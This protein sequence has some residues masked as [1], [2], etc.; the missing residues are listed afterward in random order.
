MSNEKEREGKTDEDAFD[1]L[2]NSEILFEHSA[3]RVFFVSPNGQV[4][5]PPEPQILRLVQFGNNITIK[6]KPI[7]AILQIGGMIYPLVPGLAPVLRSEDGYYMLTNFESY[8][9]GSS[10]GLEL[11]EEFAEDFHTALNSVIEVFEPTKSGFKRSKSTVQ[12]LYPNGSASVRKVLT[13]TVNNTPIED[14]ISEGSTDDAN[15]YSQ[16]GSNI[17]ESSETTV[18]PSSSSLPQRARQHIETIAVTVSKHLVQGAMAV[19]NKMYETLPIVLDYLHPVSERTTVNTTVKDNV[20]KVRSFTK[21]VVETQDMLLRKIIAAVQC[22]ARITKQQI[23]TCGKQ[24]ADSF[25]ISREDTQTITEAWEIVETSFQS[26]GLLLD[27]LVR[28]SDILA[29]ALIDNTV[30]VVQHTLGYEVAEVTDDA[31]HAMDNVIAAGMD[32]IILRNIKRYRTAKIITRARKAVAQK[33]D[34]DEEEVKP[35]SSG[36][37]SSK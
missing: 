17:D 35:N 33:S 7:S 3:V 6:G 8:D 31:L 1:I 29:H 9:T 12:T 36:N 14:E 27:G 5:T 19:S 18:L 2:E 16:H 23:K 28:S 24:L 25:D 21:Q 20:R 26:V 32:V 10:I 30:I 11:P 4:S 34:D 37:N 22:L 15:L 13:A